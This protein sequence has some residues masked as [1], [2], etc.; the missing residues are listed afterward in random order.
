MSS[1]FTLERFVHIFF[2]HIIQEE[3]MNHFF[4]DNSI[5]MSITFHNFI[6]IF[7]TSFILCCLM[8]KSNLLTIFAIWNEWKRN[9]KRK[10]RRRIKSLIRINNSTWENISQSSST[11]RF[12]SSLWCVAYFACPVLICY[13]SC[14]W[15]ELERKLHCRLSIWVYRDESFLHLLVRIHS[16][17]LFR[18]GMLYG[19]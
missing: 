13:I 19:M 5:L 11:H 4:F 16:K 2:I 9:K 14:S 18:I 6:Y 1:F 12:A 15:F 10:K 17:F 7:L 3:E 8:W